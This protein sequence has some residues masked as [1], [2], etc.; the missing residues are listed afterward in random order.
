MKLEFENQYDYVAYMNFYAVLMNNAGFL[1]ETEAETDNDVYSEIEDEHEIDELW[2]EV[3]VLKNKVKQLQNIQKETLNLLETDEDEKTKK[4]TKNNTIINGRT[5]NKSTID[6]LPQYKG[7]NEKGYF[8]VGNGSL[9]KYDIDTVLKIK[10]LMKKNLSW[11]EI[12]GKC[13]LTANTVQYIGYG[14]ETGV[15]DEYINENEQIQA[16]NFYNKTNKNLTVNN[17]QKRKELMGMG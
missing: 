9:S 11:K 7:I 13:G 12:A 8:I 3:L 1:K 6:A 17:P 5:Y 4:K 10:K 2:E 14:V 15:F 16:N